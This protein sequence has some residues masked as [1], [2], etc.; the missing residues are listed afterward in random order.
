MSQLSHKHLV[1]LHGV[2]LGKDSECPLSPVPRCHPLCARVRPAC[3]P[4][5]AGIMVQEYIRHGPLDLYLKKNHSEGKVTTSWKL[6][7][8]KQLGYALNYLVSGWTKRPPSSDVPPLP[9]SS[10]PTAS[11]TCIPVAPNPPRPMHPRPRGSHPSLSHISKRCCPF[12][13]ADPPHP[14]PT[15]PQPHSRDEHQG[16]TQPVPRSGSLSPPRR[17][18]KSP[19]A[20]FLLRRCC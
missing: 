5:P 18:R 1:L 10:I 14:T 15:A 20:T 6:Q 3:C 12:A 19:T 2:S 13:P 11:C 7:V 8:A 4:L 9:R 17:T 16:S